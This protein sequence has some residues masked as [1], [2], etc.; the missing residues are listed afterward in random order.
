MR[1][2]RIPNRV[3]PPKIS[4]AVQYTCG[5]KNV[6]VRAQV[7]RWVVAAAERDVQITIRFVA[8]DEARTMNR[9]FRKK[10]YAT[11]VLTFF[12]GVEQKK[13]TFAP[14]VLGALEGDIAICP[15]VIFKEAKEQKKAIH[16]H[17]AHMVIHGVLHL[18]GYDHETKKDVAVMESREIEL[19]RRFNITNPYE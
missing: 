12:Y 16:A 4:L 15:S 9:D 6:P 17:F 18:Q 19:L 8:P 14:Q 11:N 5:V 13:A 2:P 1:M 7:R 3:P 10:D